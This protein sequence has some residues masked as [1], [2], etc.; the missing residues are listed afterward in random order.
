MENLL[1]INFLFQHTYSSINKEKFYKQGG[2]IN[3]GGQTNVG[4]QANVG[5]H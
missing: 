3:V 4:G 1:F 2:Q 5:G